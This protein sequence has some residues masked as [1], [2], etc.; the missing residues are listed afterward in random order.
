MLHR[1]ARTCSTV[2]VT[3]NGLPRPSAAAEGQTRI[4][5]SGKAAMCGNDITQ[6]IRPVSADVGVLDFG[7]LLASHSGTVPRPWAPFGLG[8]T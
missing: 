4:K 6:Q 2:P 5:E 8:A 3:S 7:F 1:T